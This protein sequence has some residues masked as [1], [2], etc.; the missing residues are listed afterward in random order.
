MSTEATEA[1]RKYDTE[2]GCYR[3]ACAAIP[4]HVNK[5][6]DRLARRM[7]YMDAL[8][9]HAAP[10]ED[11]V[12]KLRALVQVLGNAFTFADNGQTETDGTKQASGHAH[13]FHAVWDMDNRKELA[14]KPCRKCL[15][16]DAARNALKEAGFTPTNTGAPTSEGSTTQ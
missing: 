13:Q 7:T 16:F 10:L 3:M 1:A 8:T 12:A 4:G 11:E 6:P 15:A 9:Q 14:G 5:D 2:D